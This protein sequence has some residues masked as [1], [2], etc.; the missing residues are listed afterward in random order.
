[1]NTLPSK[2]ATRGLLLAKTGQAKI[3]HLIRSPYE[4][5]ESNLGRL[6]KGKPFRLPR[7][8][9]PHPILRYI[10]VSISAL[11]WSVGLL[12]SFIVS[13]ASKKNFL[14]V[15]YQDLY[16]D[17][18]STMSRS[19]NFLEVDMTSVIK[20]IDSELPLM[21]TH[22]IAGNRIRFDEQVIFRTSRAERPLDALSRFL[23]TL[24]TWPLFLLL[25]RH[26][27]GQPKK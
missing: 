24:F 4:I 3:I 17:P 12:L 26:L 21:T 22:R 20:K 8:N 19:A 14:R 15:Y 1:M 7:R 16:S 6:D 27:V 25:K 9:Y 2:E 23:V 18:K 10:F 11:G 5:V 13:L